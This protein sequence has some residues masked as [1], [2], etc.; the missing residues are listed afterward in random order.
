MKV[1]TAEEMRYIERTAMDTFGLPGAILMENAGAG[2]A[3]A[4]E[5]TLGTLREKKVC[6]FSGH[7]NN[8]G[9]GYVAARYI[10]NAGAKVKIF[11]LDKAEQI[12]GD[13]KLHFD[14]VRKMEID[15]IEVQSDRDWD[16]VRLALLFA[17]GVVDALLGTGFRGAIRDHY[18]EIMTLINN[19]QKPVISVDLPSGLH[20]DTG[21]VGGYCIKALKT[22][23][24]GLPKPGLLSY[25]GTE[26]VGKL[27]VVDIGLP[28]QLL[29]DVEIKQNL[30]TEQ[31]VRQCIPPRPGDTHKG[32]NG[33][34]AVIAGSEGLTGAAVLASY[35]AL[36]SGGGLVT[37]GIAQSLHD[38]MEMKC[39]EVMTRSL[40]EDTRGVLSLAAQEHIREMAQ[41]ADVLL[42]GPGLSTCGDITQ[43]VQ[44]LVQ[45]IS[46]PMVIDADGLNA[47]AKNMDILEQAACA[48]V[49]TPHPGEMARLAKIP[50]NDVQANRMEV[51]RTYAQRWGATVVLKGA[52]T[53][54]AT[55]DGQV[56]TNT[57]GNP[58]LA[59]GGTGDVLA[60][61]IAGFIGQGMTPENA[62]VAAVYIHGRTAD[63]L[64]RQAGERGILAGELLSVIPQVIKEII[65]SA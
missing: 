58:V 15:I 46:I 59:T 3:R 62:A 32:D 2:V 61:L 51:A 43:L 41:K 4:V 47:L 31:M 11:V 14:V 6:I 63:T 1:A 48:L 16:K 12:K 57:T 13:A 30:I 56:Y 60:G 18:A 49:F 7:G 40:P 52:R 25:P 21:F 45:C 5:E 44:N 36:R 17:D 42:I 33:H 65:L 55:P 8:G 29:E 28:A 34:I 24:F 37:L 39:T 38:I 54:I 50:L 10:H 35:G 26:Y 23:T 64:A 20:A 19:S 27:E 53:V 9:D 22:I